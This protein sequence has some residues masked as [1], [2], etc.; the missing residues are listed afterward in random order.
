MY[1]SLKNFV[2]WVTRYTFKTL[3]YKTTV[4]S[5]REKVSIRPKKINH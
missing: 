1:I 5:F 4:S 2:D 3:R